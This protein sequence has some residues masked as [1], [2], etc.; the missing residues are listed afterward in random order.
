VGAGLG[1][2]EGFGVRMREGGAVG[3]FGGGEHDYCV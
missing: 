2:A 1:A 3:W